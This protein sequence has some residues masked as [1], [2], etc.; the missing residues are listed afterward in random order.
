MKLA[1][2]GGAAL[3]GIAVSGCFSVPLPPRLTDD[4]RAA[5][6]RA[7]VQHYSVSIQCVEFHLSDSIGC[8]R[9]ISKVLETFTATGWF[10]LTAEGT[11][12]DFS[13]L[14][15][16]LER[17]PESRETANDPWM[18]LLSIGIPLLYRDPVGLPLLAVRRNATGQ[19]LAVDEGNGLFVR[20]SLS[21]LFNLPPDRG[22]VRPPDSEAPERLKTHLLPLLSQ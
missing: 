11:L 14:V 13:V 7:P 19:S 2:F 9:T 21:P 1:R 12:A 6:A 10:Y 18:I 5:V 20:W 8:P 15:F 16:E 4:E 22:P 17:P 3:I